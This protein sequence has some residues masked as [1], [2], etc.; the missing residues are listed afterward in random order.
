MK[1][2][3]STRMKEKSPR[4]FSIIIDSS[5]LNLLN[6]ITID[7]KRTPDYIMF[8]AL[9]IYDAYLG[10]GN[11]FLASRKETAKRG[12]SPKPLKS[13]IGDFLTKVKTE[14]NDDEN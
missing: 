8:A 11:A 2:K 1:T 5:T 9:N 12:G 13:I 3:R 7:T 14:D 10:Q 4:A 6:K